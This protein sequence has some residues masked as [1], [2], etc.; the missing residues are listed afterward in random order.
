MKLSRLALVATL[1][2]GIAPAAASAAEPATARNQV[3]R[4]ARGGQ[5]AAAKAAA[6]AAGTS[7]S[8]EV[9]YV[10]SYAPPG[11]GQSA[12]L[13]LNQSHSFTVSV[14]ATDQH[15]GNATGAGVALPQTDTFGY[16]SLPTLTQN[17]SNPE[18]FVKVLDGRGINGSFWIFY[19]HLTDLIYD[20][21]V[22]DN[23]TNISKTYH[24][25]AGNQPGG[26]DTESFP[27]GLAHDGRDEGGPGHAARR[28]RAD[29]RRHLEQ[30]HDR[31]RQRDAPVLLRD[32]RRLAEL[33][34]RGPRLPRAP[35]QLPLRRHRFVPR[36]PGRPRAGG[37]GQFARDAARHLHQPS[38][39]HRV[40]G[41]GLAR[42]RT[43]ASRRS[44]RSGAPSGA[45]SP[46]RSSSTRP[47]RRSSAP[48]TTP[49]RRP[50]SRP[51]RSARSSGSTTR[52][53]SGPRRP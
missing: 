33:Q 12:D 2:A 10:R 17:P 4:A 8:V 44:I 21:T 35:G 6:A 5:D 22:T 45:G 19:G 25:D 11:G 24:K 1:A 16:F 37:P 30:H 9:P 20:L 38:V 3:V 39:Q 29:L 41:H 42:A 43:T 50:V 27:G 32:Q 34:P 26:F 49:C 14:V 15:H 47:R 23:V 7:Y 51:A 36:R 31:R 13:V 40:G 48:R 53:P 28:V 52:T 46:R 18:V